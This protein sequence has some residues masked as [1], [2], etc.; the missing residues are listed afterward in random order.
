MKVHG[1]AWAA[2]AVLLGAGPQAEEAK[3]LNVFRSDIAKFELKK[4]DGW[5]FTSVQS[6]LENRADVKMKDE[7]FQKAVQQMASAPLVVV[8]KH[9]ESFDDLNPTIQVLVRPLG[10]M[11]GRSGVEILGVVIPA[12]ESQFEGFE[13][14]EKAAETQVGGQ[15]AGR[16]TVRYTLV[17][18]DDREFSTQ[19]TI[20][21]VPRGKV[22][23]Q[24]GFSGPAGGPDA[25]TTE[26]DDVL[27]TVTF[28][29]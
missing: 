4:P 16:A 15:A 9:E 27:G 7:E 18:Q 28:L 6:A 2:L 29:D 26:I 23:Y 5:R 14:I 8:A 24:I 11:E 13:L 1:V 22:L 20:V 3:D 17:T 12:L 10:Q 21:M 19:A 25:F